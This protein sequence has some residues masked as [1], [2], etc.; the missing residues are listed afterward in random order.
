MSK[1]NNIIIWRT[2]FILAL[3]P[4][5]YFSYTLFTD[6][7]KSVFMP[8]DLTGGHHQIG[9]DCMA[10]HGE[11]FSDKDIIQE[12]CVSCHGD[13]RKKPFDSHPKAKFT[14]PRNAD[15]L[16]NINATYCVS[17]H[18]EH[19][20]ELANKAGLT[21]PEDFCVH[22]H[23]DIAKDRPSHEG[24]EFDTCASAGCHNY[25]NNRS[26]YTDFLVKHMDKPALL[27]KR[28]VP[29]KEFASVLDEIMSYPHDQYPVKK[30]S[31]KDIDAPLKP[32]FKTT[33][34]IRHDW[35]N[36]AHAKAGAN[37]SACHISNNEN[38]KP[39]WTDTPDHTACATCHDVEVKHFMQG[40]HGMRLKQNL[41]PMTTEMARLPMQ[42]SAAGKELTCN[43]CHNAHAYEL[44]SASVDAC[45]DCH[46]DRHSLNYKSSSHY[47]LWL[48]EQRGESPEGSGVSCATCHMPRVQVDV[49]DWLRRTVVQHNQN[50][51]LVPNEKMIRPACNHCH[52]LAFT[53]D[54]LA[55][56][57]L[58]ENNF[59]S[60]PSIHIKSID[61]AREDNQRHLQKT[62]GAT[63]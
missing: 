53:I 62:G 24:M 38:S 8:G 50:A 9:V 33:D 30:L 26:L 41:S 31:L 47:Q 57:T 35:L 37:C 3:L 45:L 52:G 39:V 14:D 63:D 28:T 51:T 20:P 43:S 2:W 49:N 1:H 19:Q 22:C 7:D 58:I 55:D 48:K 23:Q 25:H 5:A 59:N 18:V 17:C 15:R 61:M 16:E 10:C 21:Q 11:S 4:V 40:K 29:E 32:Q 6:K 46:N 27:E 60:K 12:R 56:E 13:Q 42:P 54:S 34:K 44:K 36:T